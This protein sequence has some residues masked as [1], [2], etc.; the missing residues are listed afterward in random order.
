MTRTGYGLMVGRMEHEK[1]NTSCCGRCLPF[2]CGAFALVTVSRLGHHEESKI[3]SEQFG[4]NSRELRVSGCSS[5][6]GHLRGCP[7]VWM[8]QCIVSDPSY[9]TPAF[10]ERTKSKGKKN[11][12]QQQ[13]LFG[14]CFGHQAAPVVSYHHRIVGSRMLH[15]VTMTELASA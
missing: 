8:K 15:E 7:W 1:S 2:W 6:G 4:G 3:R 11:T 5:F 9:Q 12:E 10:F 14:P 13:V